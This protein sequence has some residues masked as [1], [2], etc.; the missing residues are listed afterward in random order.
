MFTDS[1][2]DELTPFK[3]SEGGL[4]GKDWCDGLLYLSL[5]EG[6]ILLGSATDCASLK[7]VGDGEHLF[8]T[9]EEDKDDALPSGLR[10]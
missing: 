6:V 5:R 1:E 4:G 2:E 8:S 7:L 10:V 9:E 3:G